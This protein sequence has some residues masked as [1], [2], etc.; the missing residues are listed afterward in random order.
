[1]FAYVFVNIILKEMA[2]AK[3]TTLKDLT[4]AKKLSFKL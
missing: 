2:E 3:F 4:F 1:M